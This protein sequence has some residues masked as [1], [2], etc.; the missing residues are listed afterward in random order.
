MG[1][2]F[3][4]EFELEFLRGDIKSVGHKGYELVGGG[5]GFDWKNDGKFVGFIF[6]LV[7]YFELLMRYDSA[8]V[9]A[10]QM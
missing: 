7:Q 6:H 2:M 5:Y 4:Y 1:L 8:E 3:D 10:F 9:K